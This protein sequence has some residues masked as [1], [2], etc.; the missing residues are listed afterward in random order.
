MCFLHLLHGAKGARG[1]VASRL[2]TQSSPYVL[3]R[4]HFDMR[5]QLVAEIGFEARFPE[6]TKKA[7]GDDA[8]PGHAGYS[9]RI[10]TGE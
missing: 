8:Q 2:G 6:L 1:R 4:E 7:E 3:F 9:F 5:M 10:S